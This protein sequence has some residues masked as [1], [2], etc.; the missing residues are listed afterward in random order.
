MTEQYDLTAL[1]EVLI[2]FT[3]AGI[4]AGGMRLFEQN[5]GGAVANVLAAAAR[6]GC[7]TAFLGK[8]GADMHGAFLRDTLQA[9]GIDTGGLIL[10]PDFFTTLAFVALSETGERT[11]SFAR[12]PGA[13]TQLRPE[14]LPAGILSHTRI[15]HVGSL[16]LTAEP[17]RSATFA[18][19]EQARRGGAVISYDPN[20][21]ASLWPGR[22]T[23]ITHMRSVLPYVDVMKLS[24]EETVLL[25]GCGDAEEAAL[26]LTRAGIS[27]VAVTLGGAGA[28][29]C[30]GEETALVP[31]F[32]VPVTDTTGAGDAFWGGFLSRLLALGKA[33]GQCTLDD[34][35]SFARWGC[36]TAALCIQRR[37]A[38]P[39]MPSLAQVEAFLAAH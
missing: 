36:A 28:L 26:A 34:V 13:D 21:R 3:E 23:A 30:A 10:D 22:E 29:V 35:R 1:G 16:S 38:I 33:P 18:A 8:A 6:F 20:Y 9:A 5:P 17:A 39:A 2:D 7:K 12:K 37:G 31:G 25:T 4:S 14:E 24:G 32:Q 19:L 27:C 15:L 11:F